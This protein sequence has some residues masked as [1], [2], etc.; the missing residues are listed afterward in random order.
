MSDASKTPLL[1]VRLRGTVGDNPDIQKTLESLK[2][3][4]VNQAR[5]LKN[6]PSNIGMLRAAKNLVAWGEVDAPTLESLLT[7]RAEPETSKTILDS[8]FI[9][10]HL[11]KDDFAA[12]ASSI[13]TGETLLSE[14]W[15]A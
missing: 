13:V 9:K 6:E 7:K 8:N 10:S 12:L 15:Q 14:L 11:G 5:L 2:L 4:R 1:A 3:Q